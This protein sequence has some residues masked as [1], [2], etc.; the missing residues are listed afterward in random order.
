M[1]LLVSWQL[2]LFLCAISFRETLEKVAPVENPRSTGQLLRPLALPAAW[3]QSLRCA[4][5]E[6]AVRFQRPAPCVPRSRL[7]PA[8]RGAAL[9]QREKD[10]SA[11][12]WNS[13]GLRYGRRRAAPWD[14]GQGQGTSRPRLTGALGTQGGRAGQAMEGDLKF[15]S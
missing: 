6:S 10:L 2:M 4:P 3:E 9:V 15:L 5:R 12:N 14:I 8:P 13:F 1:N 7:I 11:Y